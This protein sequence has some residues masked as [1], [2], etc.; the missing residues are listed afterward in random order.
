MNTLLWKLTLLVL[1]FLL[2]FRI[3]AQDSCEGDP[4]TSLP[5]AQERA[6]CYSKLVT[7][8]K[9]KENTL[10]GEISH[11]DN[12]IKLTTLRIDVAQKK[13]DTLLDEIQ[14][15]ETEVERL[16]GIL[17]TRLDL[18]LKRIPAAYKR[19]S[20]SQFGALLLSRDFFDFLTRVKYVQTVQ[21]EDAALVFQ[22]KTTQNSYNESKQVR[23]D[24]K[25]QLQQLQNELEAQK[26]DLTRQ[27]KA[28]DILL[29]E[30]QGQEGIYQR[31]LAQA[32]AERQALE[33]ALID[34][35]KVGPI[36][37]GEPIA[38]VGNT[39]YPG[40]STGAHLHFEVRSGGSWRDPG[41]YLSNKTVSEDG[42]GSWTTGSGS[43]QWPLQD[44]IILTQRFG[45]TP[46]SYRYSYSG[47]IHTGF[48]MVPGS[49]GSSVIRAPADGELYA[50]SQT[51]GGSSIIKIKYIDH[52]GGVLSFYLHV[53]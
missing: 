3:L 47:G 11:M 27:K 8:C 22:V 7:A 40:C 36:K 25:N 12:Q 5:D 52:G 23:E 34:S 10:A 4:C 50:S 24:K 17:N 19:A 29:K 9:N 41:A 38:I 42:G 30:T 39:G 28:K 21:Q 35:V 33:R 37:A 16:E 26:A 44:P 48:D 15:L 46:W 1:F 2:P 45:Q 51:C 49:G 53:Q 13:I 32:L 31:L 43:W 20:V 14:K 6:N 18:L